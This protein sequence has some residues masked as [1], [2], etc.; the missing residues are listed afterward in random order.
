[1]AEGLLFNLHHIYSGHSDFSPRLLALACTASGNEISLWIRFRIHCDSFSE[2]G[3]IFCS[4]LF[5]YSF[6]LKRLQRP[7]CLLSGQWHRKW[8][9]CLGDL[10]SMFIFLTLARLVFPLRHKMSL[11]LTGK[12]SSGWS[13]R[14]MTRKAPPGEALNAE[15]INYETSHFNIFFLMAGKAA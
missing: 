15:S 13:Q 10:L 2:H 9:P 7:W 1:M 12:V 5:F 3:S 14:L 11:Q 6:V 8:F 4:C